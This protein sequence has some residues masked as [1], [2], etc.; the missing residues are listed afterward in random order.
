MGWLSR[1]EID[2]LGFLHVGQS[3]QISSRAAIYGAAEMSIGDHSRI[4]DFCVLSG[5]VTIGRNVHIAVMSN[6]A[7]GEPGVTMQDF[8]GLAYGAQVF[9]Q[10]DDYSGRSL[11]NPT[12][13]D[14]YKTEIKRPVVLGRH[15]IIGCNSVI[16]PGVVVAEGCAVGALSTVLS[17]TDP[18]GVYVG[19]PARRI[20][21]RSQDLLKLED[22]YLG[23]QQSS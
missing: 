5:K 22:E 18:W 11:T 17:S 6:V 16:M 19:S 15:V 4:D 20:R 12:V 7:G 1:D 14:A 3:V 9:A 8:S 13:P 21:E 23:R 2:G 10:S